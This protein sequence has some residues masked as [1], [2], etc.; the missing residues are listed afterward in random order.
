MLRRPRHVRGC[1]ALLKEEGRRHVPGACK[2]SAGV[3]RGDS[4]RAICRRQRKLT[5][6][7]AISFPMHV[8]PTAPTCSAAATVAVALVQ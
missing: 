7:A 2:G 1:S 4:A 8:L 6:Y 5:P 3:T